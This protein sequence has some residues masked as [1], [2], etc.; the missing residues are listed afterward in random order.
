MASVASEVAGL[1][2]AFKNAKAVCVGASA[3]PEL[4]ETLAK[5]ASSLTVVEADKAALDKLQ[6]AYGASYSNATFETP[7]Q[8]SVLPAE[9]SG[10]QLALA[11]ALISA[12]DA[13]S[14][15]SCV[16]NSLAVG[17]KLV[18]IDADGG[19]P[20]E[21]QEKAEAAVSLEGDKAL[22]LE[23]V[24]TDS[25]TTQ[26]GSSVWVFEK[27]STSQDDERFQQFLDSS[28]YTREG[29]LRYEQIFGA[30][31]V[32]TGGPD[33]TKEFC[34]MLDLK[35]G[36]SVLDVG[37]GLGG[38]AY[39]MAKEYGVSVLGIDLSTNMVDI[40]QERVPDAGLG[41]RVSFKVADVTK[42]DY[43]A[44]SFDVIY[45]RDT[46]LHITDK[47]ALFRKFFEWLKPGGRVLISDYCCGAGEPSERFRAYVAQRRYDLHT[48]AAYGKMLEGA[49]FVDVDAQDRTD[50]F[51]QCL[52]TEIARTEAEKESFIKLHGE[53]N[54]TYIIDGWKSK[55][56]R[57]A[58]GDQ[59]W[60]LFLAKKPE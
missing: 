17:G 41:D 2:P 44:G 33:T 25:L 29:I 7:A 37:S 54:Y 10:Y 55:V 57:C 22:R 45:S 43:G 50:H 47:P 56:V 51:V 42:Q 3:A 36:Q 52:Q 60:G 14:N 8:G 38:S 1:L 21:V 32:S 30:G 5:G 13:A 4:V 49:G 58:D 18:L 26:A 9:A 46:I 16:L 53:H 34:A 28:Q 12:G 31:F 35:A 48:P 39:H 24:V 6:D 15:V 40:A 23:I 27:V 19:K 20:K 59:K 11:F